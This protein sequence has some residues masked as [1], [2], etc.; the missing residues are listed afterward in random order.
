MT[1]SPSHPPTS[2]TDLGLLLRGHRRA[3]SLTQEELARLAG[4]SARAVSDIERGLRRSVYRDTA[5]RLAAALGLGPDAR[6]E[7]LR[8]ARRGPAMPAAVVRLPAPPPTVFR[9][10]EVELARLQE[11]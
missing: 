3:A 11:L 5:D 9:G 8:A 2:P 1:D 6:A 10:R 4:I 7:L